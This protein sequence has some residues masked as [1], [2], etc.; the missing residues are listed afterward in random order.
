[1]IDVFHYYY[2]IFTVII[3]ILY[4]SF[5]NHVR[6]YFQLVIW[7]RRPIDS[8]AIIIFW[9]N[10]RFEKTQGKT[11]IFWKNPRV[12]GFFKKLVFFPTLVLMSTS[13]PFGSQ[14]GST[15][16]NCLKRKLET[17][18]LQHESKIEDSLQFFPD[19]RVCPSVGRLVG[20]TRVRQILSEVEY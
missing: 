1:M 6:T 17:S 9:K 19:K 7:I 12:A 10:P 18:F 3:V 13:G 2:D 14:N 11:H 8:C 20:R 4:T 16:P 5:K 15:S